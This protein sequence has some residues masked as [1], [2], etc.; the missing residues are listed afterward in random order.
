MFLTSVGFIRSIVPNF[1]FPFTEVLVVLTGAG[2]T[3]HLAAPLMI[4]PAMIDDADE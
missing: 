2:A 4:A 3:A 1:S